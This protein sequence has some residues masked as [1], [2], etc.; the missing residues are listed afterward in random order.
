MR[1]PRTGV[2]SRPSL[3]PQAEED[4]DDGVP[5]KPNFNPATPTGLPRAR[6]P[7]GEHQHQYAR[8]QL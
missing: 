2:P 6:P 8:P 7:R 1:E 4:D 3:P 5:P